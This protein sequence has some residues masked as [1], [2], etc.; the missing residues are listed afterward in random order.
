MEYNSDFKYDLEIIKPD[1]FFVNEDGAN[2]NKKNLCKENNV[3]YIV[4]KRI[5][6]KG[7]PVRSSTDIK[8]ATKKN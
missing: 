6:E 7:L 8:A 3:E 4:A 5:P 2:D 1:I